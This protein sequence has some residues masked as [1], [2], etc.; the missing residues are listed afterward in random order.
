MSKLV[1][2]L[3]GLLV[4]APLYG[5][6]TQTYTGTIKDLSGAVVTSGQVLFTLT[7][8]TSSTIPGTGSFVPT[9][10]ACSIG[11]GGTLSGFVGGVVSGACVVTANISLS[12]A[13]TAYRICE[14]PYFQ[15]PGNCFFDYALG[16]TKDISSVAPTLSTGPINYGGTPGPAGPAGPPGTVTATGVSGAFTVPGTL[17]ASTYAYGPLTTQYLVT[18]GDSVTAGAFLPFPATQSWPAQLTTLP[19]F[20]NRA[21]L[22]NEAVSGS[23]C[24]AMTARYTT[25][26]QPFKPN[27]STITK[28]YLTVMIGRN[29]L[30]GTASALE[31]CIDAYVTQANTDGF[32]VALMTMIP[33]AMI[34]VP[35]AGFSGTWDFISLANEQIRVAVNDYIRRDALPAYIIDS[36]QFL[37]NPYDVNWTFDGTHPTPTTDALFAKNINTFFEN[38]TPHQNPQPIDSYSP[39]FH[40]FVQ[41]GDGAG[42]DLLGAGNLAQQVIPALPGCSVGW[43][44]GGAGEGDI[45]CT[46]ITGSGV[47]INFYTTNSAGASPVLLGTLAAGGFTAPNFTASGSGTF[48]G[49]NFTA[50]A[51]MTSPFFRGTAGNAAIAQGG[52]GA[53]FDFAVKNVAGSAN[54]YL[55][56][57]VGNGTD[58][59]KHTASGFNS[60]KAAPPTATTAC[61]AGDF[62][63]G[64]LVGVAYHFF[65]FATNSWA[66]VAMTNGGW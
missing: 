23:N 55:M 62:W 14:Q 42:G 3:L 33:S 63:D 47:G 48:A 26:V 9:T 57:D 7:P 29:D 35:Y 34:N 41:G 66:R 22:V 51:A 60:I 21:T 5:Q 4:V 45:I 12:P 44:Y 56:D 16:G 10:I 2:F 54:I 37:A 65:C 59:G 17:T 20:H 46:P 19:F 1:R 49:G 31:A 11:S 6:T 32:T 40:G 58:N 28:S 36:A 8:P 38:L 43:N 27:G 61:V 39:I 53:S 13:G 64:I 18:A 50:S 24:A 15:T 52:A 30:G 25:T